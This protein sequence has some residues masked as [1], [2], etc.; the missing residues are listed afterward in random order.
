MPLSAAGAEA[1]LLPVHHLYQLSYDA[2]P[3]ANAFYTRPA[4]HMVAEAGYT[5]GE[6]P[7]P[8]RV[9]V[10]RPAY[11]RS[12]R[13]PWPWRTGAPTGVLDHANPTTPKPYLMVL[14][15]D[16]TRAAVRCIFC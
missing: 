12:M 9:Q 10:P 14:W 6:G 3:A 1:C 11:Q 8:R 13:W 16:A 5:Q 4:P 15:M 2:Q 7:V